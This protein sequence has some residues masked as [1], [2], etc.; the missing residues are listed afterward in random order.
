MTRTMHMRDSVINI[1][2]IVGIVGILG[3]LDIVE[4]LTMEAVVKFVA[5]ADTG[6][7]ECE[8]LNFVANCKEIFDVTK[9]RTCVYTETRVFISSY[10]IVY[11]F[12]MSGN[13]MGHS[14]EWSTTYWSTYLILLDDKPAWI[15]CDNDKIVLFDENCNVLKRFRLTIPMLYAINF[16][17][18]VILKTQASGGHQLHILRYDGTNIT[19][20]IFE[21]DRF[22][23]TGGRLVFLD[24][25]KIISSAPSICTSIILPD[26]EYNLDSSCVI[27]WLFDDH[28]YCHTYQ[29]KNMK[30]SIE[31]DVPAIDVFHVRERHSNYYYYFAIKPFNYLGHSLRFSD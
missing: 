17:N 23:Y 16:N 9:I 8:E 19:T 18:D 10:Y 12:D 15:D 2:D 4:I 20:P 28:Y 27:S 3:I 21:D 13:F 26:A 1:L 25:L 24:K 30:V 14:N 11:S 5:D 29:E 31:G 22:L 6:I 7:V